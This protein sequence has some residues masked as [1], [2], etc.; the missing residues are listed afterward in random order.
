MSWIGLPMMAATGS[1]T[2]IRAVTIRC[3]V[4]LFKADTGKPFAQGML[5]F[6]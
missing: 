1:G 4:R 6:H 5:S 2:S 3:P